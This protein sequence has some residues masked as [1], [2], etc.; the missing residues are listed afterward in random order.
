[1]SIKAPPPDQSALLE[2][3][4]PILRFLDLVDIGAWLVRVAH[5]RERVFRDRCNPFAV[6]DDILY[7]R[8]RF[9]SDIK[10]I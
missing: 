1:M 2:N 3:G 4:L 9:S 5:R 8:Y 7:E 10:S 6:P